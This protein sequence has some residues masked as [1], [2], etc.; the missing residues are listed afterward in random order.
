M[1]FAAGERNLIPDQAWRGQDEGCSALFALCGSRIPALEG[2][3][4]IDRPYA[5]RAR[6]ASGPLNRGTAIIP[7]D[8]GDL[9]FQ[10]RA[11]M[12][13]MAGDLAVRMAG[14]EELVLPALRPG[15]VY[16]LALTRVLAAGT[17][18]GSIVVL[19]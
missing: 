4:M 3:A 7:D 19:A 13:G 5:D 1:R 14:G 16:P 17:T 12:V 11:V 8:T 15:V 6:S 9:P 2:P 18:A 10:T